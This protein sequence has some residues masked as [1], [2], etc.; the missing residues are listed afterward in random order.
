MSSLISVLSFNVFIGSPCE[1]LL[2]GGGRTLCKSKRLYQQMNEI[3][4]EEADVIC[5]QGWI[6]NSFYVIYPLSIIVLHSK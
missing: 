5:L 2:K 4:K 1:S 6:F 3:V